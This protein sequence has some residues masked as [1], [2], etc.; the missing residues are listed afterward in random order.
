MQKIKTFLALIPWPVWIILTVV[1]ALGIYWKA[2]DISN[3]YEKKQQ[4][5][6]DAKDAVKQKEID[7]LH[8]QIDA[9][10]AL[11][12]AAE[13]K[14]Q[15]A[16]Q[17]ADTL[18]QLIAARGGKIEEEQKKIDAAADKFAEDSKLIEAAGRGEISK[19]QLCQ[20]QC[21]DSAIL[22]YPCPKTYCDKWI[23]K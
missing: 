14:E 15:I 20:K 21:S 16:A 23:G 2:G 4:A 19:L 6:F 22:G 8:K 12:K 13:A 3:W 11:K 1:I 9:E 17:K 10:I 7:D 5:A 18:E